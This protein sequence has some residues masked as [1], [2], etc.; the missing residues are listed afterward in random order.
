MR[1]SC[2]LYVPESETSVGT[3]CFPEM[4]TPYTGEIYNYVSLLPVTF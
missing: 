3:A 4:F 1:V 2:P